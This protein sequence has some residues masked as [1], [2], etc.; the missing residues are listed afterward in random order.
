MPVSLAVSI[1]TECDVLTVYMW[2]DDMCSVCIKSGV[3]VELIRNDALDSS[4]G[5][6]LP[7][8][9]V[10]LCSLCH[11]CLN[12]VIALLSRFHMLSVFPLRNPDSLSEV[13][14]GCFVG[15]RASRFKGSGAYF[16]FSV[17]LWPNPWFQVRVSANGGFKHNI[18]N[19]LPYAT[20]DRVCVHIDV[21]PSWVYKHLLIWHF[22][23]ILFRASSSTWSLL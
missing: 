23:T 3:G 16:E 1:Y 22:K 7:L 4:T 12:W 10:M 13:I 14:F 20:Y 5:L 9:S 18:I 6:F 19:S 15:L 11:M 2:S 8:Y 17:N 21:I